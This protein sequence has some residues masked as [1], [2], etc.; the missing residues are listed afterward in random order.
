MFLPK[1][2]SLI[3]PLTL[4]ALIGLVVWY[5]NFSRYENLAEDRIRTYMEAQKVDLNQGVQKKS[6]KDH[7][8]GRWVI[9]YKFEDE[10]HLL[11]EYTYDKPTNR[12]MLIV[13]QTPSM[14]GGSGMEYGMNY[15]SLED[16]WSMFDSKGNLILNAD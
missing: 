15:P 4:L 5:V 7:K 16:G 9:A 13:Y 1:R 3:I 8:T 10:P 14:M 2:M 11:Y 12:V 6:Q